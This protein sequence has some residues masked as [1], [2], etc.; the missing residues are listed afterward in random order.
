MDLILADLNFRRIY[1]LMNGPGG[2]VKTKDRY[3]FL[4]RV[5]LVGRMRDYDLG[6]SHESGLRI[7]NRPEQGIREIK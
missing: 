4:L 2:N 1:D 3:L 7:P 5:T 6:Q